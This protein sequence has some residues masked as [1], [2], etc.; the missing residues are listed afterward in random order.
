V[1]RPAAP[2]PAPPDVVLVAPGVG[3]FYGR[4]PRGARAWSLRFVNTTGATDAFDYTI[5][6]GRVR[7]LSVDSAVRIVLHADG[8]RV[9]EP[10]D[11]AIHSPSQTVPTTPPLD[12]SIVQ[13]TEP[14]FLVVHA[15]LALSADYRARGRCLLV[16]SSMSARVYFNGGP[17]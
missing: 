8:A 10:A 16:G 11:G 6:D 12:V 17:P 9:R 2:R 7:R 4:C 1:T 14:E 3:A 15:H 13:G 5:G